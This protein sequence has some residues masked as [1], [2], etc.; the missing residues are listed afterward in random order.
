MVAKI[1][2]LVAI[3]L[4]LSTVLI[5]TLSENNS[6]EAKSQKLSPAHSYSKWTKYVCG[7]ELCKDKNYKSTKQQIGTSKRK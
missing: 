7:D 4:L 1:L 3:T 2:G 6:A 5:M